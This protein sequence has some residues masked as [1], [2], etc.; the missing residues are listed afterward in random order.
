MKIGPDNNSHHG[1]HKPDHP[2]GTL[3]GP[4]LGTECQQEELPTKRQH[5][6]KRAKVTKVAK[7]FVNLNSEINAL[8]LQMK[9]L[10]EKISHVSKSAHSSF[11]RKKIRTMKRE[12]DKVSAALEKSEA[13]LESMRV[14]KDPVSG[15]PLKL[16]SRS[17][18]KCIEVKIAELNKKIR[19][20]KNTWSKQCLIAK[21][22]TLHAEV[23]WGPH[24][25]EGAFGGTYRRHRIDGL[26]GMDP[27]TFLNR[28]RRLIIDLMTKESRTRAIHSQATI[29]IRFRKDGEM[30]ELAFNSRMLNVYNLSDMNE[31]VNAMITHTVQ[32]IENPTLSDSKLVF[33][34]VIRMDV[35]FH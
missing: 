3:G 18:P 27:E 20:A 9:E 2:Q 5:K 4:T 22:E 30:V 29:W 31:I 19:R 11:T 14:P 8:K 12:V 13:C 25:L 32:Q 24:R 1:L 15:V 28:V 35:D 10:N 34:E 7:K 21:R 26:P 17:R 16:H 6:H 33:N 23:S